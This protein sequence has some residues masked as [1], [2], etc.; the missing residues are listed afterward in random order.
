MAIT[1]GKY[2]TVPQTNLDHALNGFTDLD[3]TSNPDPAAGSNTVT[4]DGISVAAQYC[5]LRAI[6]GTATVKIINQRDPG[7][8]AEITITLTEDFPEPVLVSDDALKITAGDVRAYYAPL[9]VY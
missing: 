1:Y 9:S 8:P 5:F 2:E 7:T 6:G 4:I 3:S